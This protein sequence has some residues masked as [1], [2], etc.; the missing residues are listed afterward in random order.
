MS[1]MF[2]AALA[3]AS[4]SVLGACTTI[5]TPPFDPATPAAA[6]APTLP[7]S[8]EIAA[9]EIK[10]AVLPAE[11]VE[12]SAP[13]STPAAPAA[14][15]TLL[16][17]AQTK[18][19]LMS[20]VEAVRGAGLESALEG[21]AP[22]TIFAPNN[23]AFEFAALGGD[24]DIAA[25]LSGHII[26]GALDMAALTARAGEA[27]SAKLSTKAGTELTLFVRDDVIKIAGPNGVLGRI[28]QGDMIQSNG[29]M[30]QISS[31]LEAK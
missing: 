8:A 26:D 1:L 16:Y 5:A 20:F 15:E 14:N 17:G 12:V 31:V 24:T 2:R 13:T 11:T 23:Q 6:E 10:P 25:L 3:A 22:V 19:E 28:T 7:A 18:W 4:L 27:G 21:T 9:A 29:V 30:H